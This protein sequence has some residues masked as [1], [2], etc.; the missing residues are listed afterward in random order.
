MWK[1]LVSQGLKY[2][3]TSYEK[4]YSEKKIKMQVFVIVINNAIFVIIIITNVSHWFLL[5]PKNWYN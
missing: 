3:P 2:A 5:K 4:A 1:E